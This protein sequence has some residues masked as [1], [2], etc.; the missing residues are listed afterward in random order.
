MAF[1]RISILAVALMLAACSQLPAA[2][3]GTV[4][5]LS[6]SET[7]H[8]QY[9]VGTHYGFRVDYHD[10]GRPVVLREEYHLPGPAHW[11]SAQKFVAHNGGRIMTREVELGTH[12]P[13]P[14]EIHGIYIAD[15]QI[16]P[17]DPRGDYNVQLSLDGKA[18]KHFEFS[19]E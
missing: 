5:G 14:P 7:R 2:R 18:W 10:S 9:A 8:I 11:R 1:V 12:A 6:V 17:G 15:L 13:A 16:A 19:I 4:D 3:F